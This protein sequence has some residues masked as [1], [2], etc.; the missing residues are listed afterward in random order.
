MDW[1]CHAGQYLLWYF[2]F[3]GSRGDVL[4]FK[5]DSRIEMTFVQYARREQPM[6][7]PMDARPNPAPTPLSDPQTVARVLDS[8]AIPVFRC[9]VSGRVTYCNQSARVFFGRDVLGSETSSF[10]LPEIPG[11]KLSFV[12]LL[13]NVAEKPSFEF[14]HVPLVF[15]KEDGSRREIVSRLSYD[16]EATNQRPLCRRRLQR[17]YRTLGTSRPMG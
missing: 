4:L 16:A 9:E 14:G 11:T 5:R 17:R 6:G 1:S 10:L 15:Q 8:L 3:L 13:G 2:T 12:E 7:S